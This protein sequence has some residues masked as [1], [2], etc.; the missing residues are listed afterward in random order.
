MEPNVLRILLFTLQQRGVDTVTRLNKAMR[1]ADF[2][3][4][5][6][7]GKDDHIAN[8]PKSA[9]QNIDRETYRAMPE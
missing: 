3:R 6:R 7:L 2:R 8:W 5:K 4:G 9:M 1:K